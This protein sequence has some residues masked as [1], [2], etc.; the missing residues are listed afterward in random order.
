MQNI[1]VSYNGYPNL[2][3]DF[4]VSS[5]KN[6]AMLPACPSDAKGEEDC[7]WP[8][9]GNPCSS[10]FGSVAENLCQGYIE[11]ET[12]KLCDHCSE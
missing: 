9:D 1:R 4:E 12:P 5:W 10:I 6:W 3:G 2:D 11:E 7:E 8:T